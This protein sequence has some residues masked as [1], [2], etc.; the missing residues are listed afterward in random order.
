[1]KTKIA[2]IL[3]LSVLLSAPALAAESVQLGPRPFYLI[4]DM[5]ESPLKSELEKMREQVQNIE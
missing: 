4:N 2:A 1:M 5:A 3:S